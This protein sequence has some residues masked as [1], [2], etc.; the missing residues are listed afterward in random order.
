[1]GDVGVAYPFAA[2]GEC[3]TERRTDISMDR[4]DLDRG[5]PVGVSNGKGVDS[6]IGT[7]VYSRVLVLG[8]A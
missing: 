1:M 3:S 6:G 2:V 8:I 4:S 7:N 5:R